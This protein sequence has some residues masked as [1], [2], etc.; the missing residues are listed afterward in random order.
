MSHKLNPQIVGLLAEMQAKNAPPVQMLSP[1]EARETRNPMLA[2]LGGSPEP[3]SNVVNRQIPGPAGDIPVRIYS[4]EGDGPFPVFVFFH[5]GGYV[6]GNLDTHDAPCRAIA[7]LTPCVVISVDYRLAPE[8]KFPA[9]AEDA[10]AATLWAANNTGEI[11]GDPARI[12]VG[13]DSAGGNLAAVVS[14]M[15][16]DKKGPD[17][18]Y[19]IL[20]YPIINL[21]SID[22]QSYTEHAEGYL[23]TREGMIYYRDHYLSQEQ[24][25]HNPYASPLLAEDH[26]GLPP[27]LIIAAEYD[28]LKDEGEAY[29]DMLS[30]AGVPVTYKLYDD[31]I[32]AFYNMA[33]VVD[34]AKDAFEDIAAGLRSLK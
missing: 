4:P 33:G 32:H 23:L 9:A 18:R 31:M 29:I 17:L 8:N 34:R 5:G 28:V 15:A 6:I 3:V 30:R 26:S 11:N 27:A 21:A 24:D 10:Y 22:T 7:N 1:K 2:E 16:R 12:A 20:I 14:L 25:A 13:G 19:Q